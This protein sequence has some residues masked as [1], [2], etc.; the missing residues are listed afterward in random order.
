MSR[1][2]CFV[3]ETMQRLYRLWKSRLHTHYKQCSTTRYERL[4][5]PSDDLRMDQWMYYVDHFSSPEF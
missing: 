4:K 3:I 1:L 2:Q 5:N